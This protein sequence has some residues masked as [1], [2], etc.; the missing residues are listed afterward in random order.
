MHFNMYLFGCIRPPVPHQ[1][2]GCILWEFS[3]QRMNFPGMARR[4]SCSMLGGILVPRPG[5]EPM[6]PALQSGFLT[7]GPPRKSLC[8]IYFNHKK[9]VMRLLYQNSQLCWCR[10]ALN[11][12]KWEPGL[13]KLLHQQLCLLPLWKKQT[14]HNKHVKRSQ[15]RHSYLYPLSSCLEGEISHCNYHEM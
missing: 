6:C 15:K 10:A 2:L 11:P 7:T 12:P 13:V 8:Y 3:M 1:D 4:L 5:I 9:G 14:N